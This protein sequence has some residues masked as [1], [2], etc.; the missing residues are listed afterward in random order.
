MELTYQ[1]LREQAGEDVLEAL[2]LAEVKYFYRFFYKKADE[3]M[4][5]AKIQF[6]NYI[7]ADCLNLIRYHRKFTPEHWKRIRLKLSGYN[8]PELREYIRLKRIVRTK[9]GDRPRV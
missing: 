9:W 7:R 8:P 5:P 4:V 3:W 2:K 1:D 6:I